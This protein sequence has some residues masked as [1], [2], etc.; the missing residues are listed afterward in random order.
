MGIEKPNLMSIRIP[1]GSVLER[2][3]RKICCPDCGADPTTCIY[4]HF[5]PFFITLIRQLD[6]F[7]WAMSMFL[8]FLLNGR[9]R[10]AVDV[11][12]YVK[13]KHN[14][15]THVTQTA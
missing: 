15:V 9:T 4:K 13:K 2:N 12:I 14:L 6:T 3:V 1:N 5:C 10:I 11:R 8:F 7:L